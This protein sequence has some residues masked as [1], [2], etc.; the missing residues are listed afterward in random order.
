MSTRTTNG[1]SYIS[2]LSPSAALRC[3]RRPRSSFH[4]IPSQQAQPSPHIITSRHTIAAGA[5]V[6]SHHHFT[7]YHR[8]RRRRRLTSSFHAIPSQQAPS[9]PRHIAADAN[10]AHRGC[11]RDE[12]RLL[13]PLEPPMRPMPLPSTRSRLA[14]WTGRGLLGSDRKSSR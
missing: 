14:C 11:H 13:G 8:S 6:A 3:S 4:V 7:Q 5:V 9:L 12:R 10:T 2:M 1:A